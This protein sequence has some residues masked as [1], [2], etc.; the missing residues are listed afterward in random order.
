MPSPTFFNPTPAMRPQLVGAVTPESI[1]FDSSAVV[2]RD[3]AIAPRPMP[4]RGELN[5]FLTQLKRVRSGSLEEVG[6]LFNTWPMSSPQGWNQAPHHVNSVT[7]VD[8]VG[9]AT[10]IVELVDGLRWMRDTSRKKDSHE[11]GEHPSVTRLI[12]EERGE[13]LRLAE[14]REGQLLMKT[15][16][17]TTHAKGQGWVTL[18]HDVDSSVGSPAFAFT[19]LFIGLGGLATLAV[20]AEGSETVITRECRNCRAPFNP[21]VTG[22]RVYC[23]SDECGTAK[24]RSAAS[25]ARVG[26]PERRPR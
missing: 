6:R 21:G 2:W 12:A 18:S 4:T 15:F 24:Q 22:T 11:A 25:Y 19:L 9:F 7:L 17:F 1:T 3:R 8:L 20:L 5:R 26:R 16:Q 13:P 14:E 23:D 10:E